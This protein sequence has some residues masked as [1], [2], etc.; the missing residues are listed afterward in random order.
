[1]DVLVRDLEQVP[2]VEGRPR[3]AGDGQRAHALPARR[4]EGLQRLAAGH[5]DQLAVEADAAHVRRA[6]KGPYSRTI[7]AG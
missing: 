3:I 2:P 4:V 5:P 7:S 1:V 6:G